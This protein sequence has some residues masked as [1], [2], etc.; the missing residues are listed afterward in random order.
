MRVATTI[1]LTPEHRRELERIVN[2]TTVSVRL[3]RR[4]R[5]I[6]LAADGLDNTAIARTLGIGRGQVGCWR[7]RFADGGIDAIVADRPRSGRRRRID[8]AEILRLTGK[9]PPAGTRA[10]STRTLAGAAGVSGTSVLQ[11]WQAAGIVGR[12]GRKPAAPDLPALLERVVGLYFNPPEHA[13][14]LA[15]SEPEINVLL[16]RA[17]DRLERRTGT[18]TTGRRKERQDPDHQ[19]LAAMGGAPG[20][21]NARDSGECH[22]AHLDFLRSLDRSTARTQ[23][24]HIISSHA[25][26]YEHAEAKRWL[27]SHPRFHLHVLP[28]VPGISIIEL[29]FRCLV[30]EQQS[31]HFR[32]LPELIA[33]IDSFV[34]TQ[35]LSPRPFS[36]TARTRQAERPVPH[37]EHH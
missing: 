6:L 7:D 1:R 26:A 3:A 14:A 33:A 31:A 34:G 2:S 28:I 29:F 19:L 15:C 10:W 9:P 37:G 32:S 8:A 13:L 22:R 20:F 36:W 24:L 23:E 27:A 30:A 4:A 16:A 18:P 12:R 25:D 21:G 35:P 11:V 17:L 5:M